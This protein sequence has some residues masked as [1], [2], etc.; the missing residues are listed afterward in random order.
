[1]IREFLRWYLQDMKSH[2]V[3]YT[4]AWLIF[5]PFL[6]GLAPALFILLPI[7]MLFSIPTA[8]SLLLLG[9]F[10]KSIW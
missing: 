9:N 4:L 5:L 2:P 10:V 8:W 1:M 7:C 6:V 3:C